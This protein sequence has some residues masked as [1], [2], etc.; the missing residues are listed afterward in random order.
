MNW[1]CRDK[2]E[3]NVGA[4]HCCFYFKLTSNT[5]NARISDWIMTSNTTAKFTWL[6]PILLSPG[7]C[8]SHDVE[9]EPK[10]RSFWDEA[11]HYNI[12]DFHS[13][14]VEFFDL[15]GCYTV[16]RR[17]FILPPIFRRNLLFLPSEVLRVEAEISF[18]I[19]MTVYKTAMSE[20]SQEGNL[21]SHHKLTYREKLKIFKLPFNMTAHSFPIAFYMSPHPTSRLMGVDSYRQSLFNIEV[22]K[23]H[24]EWDNVDRKNNK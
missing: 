7:L 15:L 6:K 2:V 17:I 4:L 22:T 19:F 5:K 9:Y 14:A 1:N 13:G 3:R 8:S 10:I 18:Q 16:D 21:H 11:C 20:T 12:S 24:E 23:S